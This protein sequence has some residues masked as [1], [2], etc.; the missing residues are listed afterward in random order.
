MNQTQ[1]EALLEQARA[2]ARAGEDTVAEAFFRRAAAID[3]ERPDIWL[4][5]SSVVH[6][7]E[8]KQ[9]CLE[10]VLALDPSDREAT[11]ALA[12][13]RKKAPELLEQAESPAS[14][15]PETPEQREVEQDEDIEPEE[16]VYCAKH[17]NVETSL[18]CNRCGKPICP[19]CAVH[20]P[21]GFRCEE[22]VQAQRSVFYTAGI[23]DYAVAGLVALVLATIVGYIMT[24]LGWFFALFLGPLAGGLI[25]EA[26]FRATGRKRGRQMWLL[27][28]AA[29]V[30]GAILPVIGL[31]LLSG[32]MDYVLS[33]GWLLRVNWVYVAFGI[34]AAIARLR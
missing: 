23:G 31:P 3:P 13:I 22:C 24:L 1:V 7:L 14:S 4:E 10:R 16:P 15:A 17:P 19:Q 29:L 33:F 11:A 18:R 20:T 8:E 2:A 9:R 5:L 28:A 21:V 32:R 25:G 34:G 26:V 30:V 27:A 12:W 6:S